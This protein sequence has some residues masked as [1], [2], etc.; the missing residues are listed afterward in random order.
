MSLITRGMGVT[1]VTESSPIRPP[2][3][4]GG[5]VG[6]MYMYGNEI[7][8]DILAETN[9]EPPVIEIPPG[10]QPLVPKIN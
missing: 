3:I 1:G 9:I 10:R 5:E 6:E 7:E 4:T 8:P 2:I